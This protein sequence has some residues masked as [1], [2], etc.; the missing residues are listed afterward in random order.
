[1]R[2]DSSLIAAVIVVVGVAVSRYW[3]GRR[4][5]DRGLDAFLK[6]VHLGDAR[7]ASD[8]A[9]LKR[10]AI[11]HVVTV[12]PAHE[13]SLEYHEEHLETHRVPI[14]DN[15]LERLRPH[16]D[17]AFAFLHR[18]ARQNLSILVHCIEGKSRSPAL[19]M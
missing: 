13:F 19:L 10:N 11:E 17:D 15:G 4:D 1:M 9:Y 5:R 2:L 7:M 6:L 3:M 18:A 12:A 14:L 8:V 16:L